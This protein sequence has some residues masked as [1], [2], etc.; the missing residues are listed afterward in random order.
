M[1]PQMMEANP[2]EMFAGKMMDMLNGAAL[3]MMTSIGHRTGLFDTMSM[4]HPATSVEIA[5]TAGLNERY[6]REWLGAMTTGG[7]VMYDPEVRTY[8][9]PPEHAA[10]LTRAAAPNNIAA[11]SQFVSVLGAV[12]DGIVDCFHKGGGL[13]YEAYTRFHAVMADE[14]AQSVG[15]KLFDFILPLAPDVMQKLE[16]GARAADFG[17]GMGRSLRK[18]AGAYLM[19]DFVGFDISKEVINTAQREANMEGLMNLRFQQRDVAAM[20]M[21]EELD[22]A[23]AF[24]SIHDQAHPDRMLTNIY[25]AL[26]PGGVFLIQEIQGHTHVHDNLEHPMAPFVY[27]VSCMHCMSVSLSQGG[28]G[29]GAAWGEELAESMLLAAGF[30]DITK[31]RAEGDLMS[32]FFV[33]RKP[34]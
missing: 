4:M 16:T 8:M 13:P 11:S 26:K 28:M 6:V 29:L 3:A 30:K 5:E 23:F 31:H 14:S 20:E 9:L 27:T 7:I 15:C 22:V 19:S 32:T 34:K 12:E 24:D 1:V 33:A 18:M 2:A 17:C 25:R 10:F 21:D